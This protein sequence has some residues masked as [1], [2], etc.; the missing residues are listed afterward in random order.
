[1]NK[2]KEIGEEINYSNFHI[3]KGKE[4]HF[5]GEQG[6]PNKNNGQNMGLISKINKHLIKLYI[7]KKTIKNGQKI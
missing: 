2:S 3:K 5:K 1:M 4:T 6:M 7:L